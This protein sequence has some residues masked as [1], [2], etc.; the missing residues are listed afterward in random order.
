MRKYSTQLASL[1]AALGL[2]AGACQTAPYDDPR[3]SYDFPQHGLTR[4]P[5]GWYL[6]QQEGPWGQTSNQGVWLLR[7]G[8]RTL[9]RPAWAMPEYS[10]SDFYFSQ[11]TSM[12]CF[13]SDRPLLS[14]IGRTDSNIWCVQWNGRSWS[15]PQPLPSSV[16]SESSEW[17]PVIAYDGAVFFASDRPGALGLGDIYRAQKSG[18]EWQVSALNEN[19]N[20]SGGEWNLDISPDG[21]VLVFE[22]SHRPT[23]RTVSGDL[24]FS[25]MTDGEW[26]VA[27]PLTK[28]NTDGSDLMPRFTSSRRFI[29][30]SVQNGQADFRTGEIE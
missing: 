17:S 16:N 1:A 7:E 27:Q 22:A 21:H 28:L 11:P 18:S 10:E 23:N 24:Y 9:L 14:H 3:L 26:G 4:G 25:R 12:G 5:D 29:F 6:T 15:D 19:V 20:T 2:V 8:S 13:V 30:T